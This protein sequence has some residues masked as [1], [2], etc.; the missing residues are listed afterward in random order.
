[1]NWKNS[2]SITSNNSKFLKWSFLLISAIIY[3]QIITVNGQHK[4]DEVCET[5]PSEI[6]LI[7]GCII[8][9]TKEKLFVLDNLK[10]YRGIR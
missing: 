1:M 4:A 9:I 7:K 2:T 6:H 10:N 3:H 5:L 8:F